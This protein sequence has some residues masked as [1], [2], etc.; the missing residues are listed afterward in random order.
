MKEVDLV[1]EADGVPE[2][3]RVP[4]ADCVPE[5]NPGFSILPVLFY[6]VCLEGDYRRGQGRR[7]RGLPEAY[8]VPEADRVNKTDDVKS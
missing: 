1:P 5:A 3:D 4:E 8:R 2:F 6:P 7:R